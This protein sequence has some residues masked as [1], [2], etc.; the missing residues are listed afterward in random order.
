MRIRHPY[1]TRHHVHT[2]PL[3]AHTMLTPARLRSLRNQ[4]ETT[5]RESIPGDYIETGVWRGGACIMMRAI[6]KALNVTDR[7]VFVA[8]SFDGLPPPSGRYWQDKRDRL[9]KFREL[10]IS[11]EQVRKHFAIYDLL[12]DQVV[13][14]KG[15]FSET[16]PKLTDECFA[17]IRLD[18]DMYESTMDA[19]TNLYPRLSPGGFAIIDDYSLQMC[20]RAVHD[21]LAAHSLKP[22]LIE[23]DPGSVYWRK[24]IP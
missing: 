1:F 17:I 22:E 15:W 13:F 11:E 9:S 18:G 5:I 8:D 12:D 6:L 4:T 24:A 7:R 2:W 19:L 16:L 21:Y 3:R 10:A 23:I 14:L 20:R